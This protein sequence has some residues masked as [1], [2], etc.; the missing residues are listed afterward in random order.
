[1]KKGKRFECTM[2]NRMSHWGA[3]QTKPLTWEG[4]EICLNCV[5]NIVRKASREKRLVN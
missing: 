3:E 2:C 4:K 1:M 5:I